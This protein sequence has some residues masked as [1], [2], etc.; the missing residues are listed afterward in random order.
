MLYDII[1]FF[2]FPFSRSPSFLLLLQWCSSARTRV[3]ICYFPHYSKSQFYVQ[4]NSRENL[5]CIEVYF[6]PILMEDFEHKM[7]RNQG[8]RF[9]QFLGQK[10]GFEDS[11]FVAFTTTTAD[12]L[13]IKVSLPEHQRN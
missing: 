7:P 1:G 12:I 4:K 10:S 13:F 9:Y 5:Q 2:F 6:E 3:S 8:F 11:V